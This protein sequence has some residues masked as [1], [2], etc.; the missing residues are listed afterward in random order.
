MPQKVY[1]SYFPKMKYCTNC[2]AI[3]PIIIVIIVYAK[4]CQNSF[5]KASLQKHKLET[6]KSVLF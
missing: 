2:F 6:S 4:K 3:M 1:L 5:C